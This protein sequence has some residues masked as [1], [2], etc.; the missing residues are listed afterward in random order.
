MWRSVPIGGLADLF[1]IDTR[2]RRD[3]PAGGDAAR[4]PGRSQLGPDQ[5]AWLLDGLGSSSA[6]WRLLGNSSVMGQ[7]W[8]DRLTSETMPALLKLKMVEPNGR[9][10]DPDQWD[11]YPVERDQILRALEDRDAVVLS[12]D[13]HIGLALE[14]KLD[15]TTD[16]EPVAGEFVTTSLT[17][18]NVDDKMG[19][20][21]RTKSIPFE[22]GLVREVPHIK[23]CDFDSH[24]YVLVDVTPERVRGEWWF[25]DTVLEPTDGE[26]LGS[27][28][29]VHRGSG[30][31]V[32]G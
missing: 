18:Q 12:G 29:E 6:A 20:P 7:I 1:I 22:E 16:Q 21:P 13:V 27:A 19:W 24:G 15:P 14:L 2:S 26:R 17:S 32:R 8:D 31:L 25:V 5:R 23:W 30:R 11:G 10:P 28:W 3:E 9:G 4:Y